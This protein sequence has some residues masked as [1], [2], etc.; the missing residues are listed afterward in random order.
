MNLIKNE[1]KIKEIG[2]VDFIIGI[3]FIK[4]TNGY[5]LHQKR[6]ISDLLNKYDNSYPCQD[7]KSIYYYLFKI[8][9]SYI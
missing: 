7:N 2:N 5:F 1:F 6:Y 8:I 3:K 4:V 9:T